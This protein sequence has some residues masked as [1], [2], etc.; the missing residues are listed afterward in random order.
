MLRALI[1]WR[2]ASTI[3]ASFSDSTGWSAKVRCTRR[4]RIASIASIDRTSG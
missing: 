4:L 3:F 1:A 2:P